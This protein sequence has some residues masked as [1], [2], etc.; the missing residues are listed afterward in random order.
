MRYED[1]SYLWPP[2]PETKI[3]QAVL[4]FYEKRG[5]WAQIKRNGTCTV[6]FAK[7]DRV[8][9]KTRHN[10]D[11]K[12]WSPK[13]EHVR[14]FQSTSTEWN[15][16]VAEL[17]HSKTPHIKDQLY[18]F[19]IIVRDGEQLVG[20][21]FEARQ[22]LLASLWPTATDEGD[23]FR[24][25]PHV[26]YAKNFKSNFAE[27]FTHLKPEDEGVVLKDPKGKLKACFKGDSNAS[28]Q[29]K[30]RIPTKNYGY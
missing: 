26:S 25:T 16:Y 22:V 20:T 17:V 6:I 24:V 7:G 27:L 23:Q 1:Y 14:F 18:L 30:S 19:D 13:P 5:F 8:I 15:V 11:H 29:V 21:T 28:W 2:R 4:P 10:D 12:Q 9:F 3:P